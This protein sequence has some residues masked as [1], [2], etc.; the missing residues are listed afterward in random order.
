VKI[1]E[2]SQAEL[3]AFVQEA[4]RK[5]GIDVVLT[6]GA[7]VAFYSTNQYVSMDIDLADN[8]FAS[9]QRIA[10]RMG[11]L[12]FSRPG[13]HFSHPDTSYLVEFVSGPPSVGEETIE[14]TDEIQ[15]RTGMLKVISPTD[16]VK[17]RLAGFYHWNDLRSLEQAV[18]VARSQRV[19]LANIKRWSKAEGKPEGFAV[20]QKKLAEAS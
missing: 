14:R 12:G 13:K 5:D 4:L 16:C 18:L 10:A 7:V 2:M 17:D 9:M 15:L 20:F 1:S 8:G 6:G 11:S 3:A 19:N